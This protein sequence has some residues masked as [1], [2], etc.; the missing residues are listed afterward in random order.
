MNY[1]KRE[2]KENT[3]YQQWYK[4]TSLPT[5][6]E[7][8]LVSVKAKP[9]PN[10]LCV[11][12]EFV[13]QQYLTWSAIGAQSDEEKQK[14]VQQVARIVDGDTNKT[15]LDEKEGVFEWPVNTVVDIIQ[16]K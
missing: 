10:N 3:F 13:M 12:R 11:T 1:S 6:T 14:I 4:M 15:W 16:R 5:F 9:F 2:Y 8:Y 7:N